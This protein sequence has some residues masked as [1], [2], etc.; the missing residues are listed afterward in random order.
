MKEETKKVLL[1]KP[2]EMLAVDIKPLKF[3]DAEPA[4]PD[5]AASS[6]SQVQV[7]MIST[8]RCSAITPGHCSSNAA[9]QQGCSPQSLL[10]DQ[11]SICS[12]FA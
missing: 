6:E 2:S 12:I 9:T 4:V 5:Q 1:F 8:G 3:L 7:L 10:M 11:P